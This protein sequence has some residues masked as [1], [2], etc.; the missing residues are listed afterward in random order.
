MS[1]IKPQT[2]PKL[3]A[4]WTAQ[5]L[6]EKLVRHMIENSLMGVHGVIEIRVKSGHCE[7]VRKTETL[8]TYKGLEG[9]LKEDRN[10]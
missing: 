4:T 8:V 2:D 9:Q 1:Q 6:A 3:I 5:S 10:V 7:S